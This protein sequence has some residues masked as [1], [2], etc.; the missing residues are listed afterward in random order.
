MSWSTETVKL[1]DLSCY[2]FSQSC[3]AGGKIAP[4]VYILPHKAK[5]ECIL[6]R[7]IIVTCEI[8]FFMWPEEKC[9]VIS[10]SSNLKM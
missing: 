3:L 1:S 10:F 7:N 4:G 2:Q 5:Q 8:I 6:P 9:T